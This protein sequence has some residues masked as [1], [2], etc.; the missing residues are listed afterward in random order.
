M[1]LWEEVSLGSF[2]SVVFAK[3]Q[4]HF[5]FLDL[6]C[7]LFS[8]KIISNYINPSSQQE[9]VFA[10]TL[11]TSRLLFFLL[12]LF[13]RQNKRK[14]ISHFIVYFFFWFAGST[15]INKHYLSLEQ[16]YMVQVLKKQRLLCRC[17]PIT[18]A[19][20]QPSVT[21]SR[22]S[23]SSICLSGLPKIIMHI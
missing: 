21:L 22:G 12:F 11:D 2:Y 17:V 10:W 3:H 9:S 19:S 18:P 15:K 20:T 23:H 4:A 6:Y 16:I 14:K 1:Y 13:G 7:Q 5:K 8:R